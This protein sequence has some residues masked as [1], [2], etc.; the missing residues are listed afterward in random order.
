MLRVV[1][2]ASRYS[3]RTASARSTSTSSSEKLRQP[4][5]EKSGRG[6]GSGELGVDEHLHAAWAVRNGG[7]Q[8][9]GEEH[10][11]AGEYLRSGQAGAL[12]PLQRFTHILQQ[13]LELRRANFIRRNLRRAPAQDFLFFPLHALFLSVTKHR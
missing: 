3:M 1:P 9:G 12:L 4:S 11:L 8:H 6:G 7:R 2:P 10:P 13:G 5:Q